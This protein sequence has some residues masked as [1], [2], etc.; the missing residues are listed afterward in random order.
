MKRMEARVSI[1]EKYKNQLVLA[2][3]AASTAAYIYVTSRWG[4]GTSPDSIVYI[5]GARSMAAGRGFS[6]PS[7][8]GDPSPIV[9]FPPLFSAVLSLFEFTGI[10]T[11]DGASMLNAILF[12][13]NIYMAGLFVYRV[14][15][16][17]MAGFIAAAFTLTA[18]AILTTHT[19]VWSEGLF[20]FFVLVTLVAISRYLRDRST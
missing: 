9:Q 6:L 16:M 3:M 10:D 17:P 20:L 1:F 5:A 4:F 12:A 7:V 2:C 19:M 11:L 14:T 15:K 18:P 13:L 8:T